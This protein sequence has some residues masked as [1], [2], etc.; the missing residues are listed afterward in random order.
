MAD[1]QSPAAAGVARLASSDA[2]EREEAAHTLFRLGCGIAEPIL[3]TWF[4]DREFRALVRGSGSLLTVGVAVEPARFQA[5][6]RAFGQ[7][8][9][10]DVPADQDVLEFGL[11][12][13]HGVRLDILTARDAGGG[14]I[15]RFLA[16]FGEG[17]QQVECDVRDVSR[18]TQI[19]RARFALEPVYPETRAG[20]DGT[21]VN[22]FLVPLP[23][24]GKVLVELVEV[25][26][27][28]TPKKK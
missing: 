10:A 26:A 14:S 3:K 4:A 7:P 13:A 22:F 5:I 17:I 12:F 27:A 1:S 25:P 2:Q 23:E 16:R 6:R 18:A 8:H 24:G 9:L 11:E 20:A 15:A 28:K 21:S 19:L